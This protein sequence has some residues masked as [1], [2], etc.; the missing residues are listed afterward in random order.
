MAYGKSRSKKGGFIGNMAKIGGS[1]RKLHLKTDMDASS[2][3][4]GSKRTG[5]KQ[6]HKKV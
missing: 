5:A 1:R 4:H 6:A 2:M 3:V